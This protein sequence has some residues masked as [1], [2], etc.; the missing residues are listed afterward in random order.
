MFV[1]I[2]VCACRYLCLCMH[3]YVHVCMCILMRE[4]LTAILYSEIDLLVIINN[5]SKELKVS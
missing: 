2:Y 4:D 3:V 1:G 5:T